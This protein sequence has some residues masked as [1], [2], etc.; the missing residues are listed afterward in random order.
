MTPQLI[1]AL[2]LVLAAG[3][4]NCAQGDEIECLSS[5]CP[6]YYYVNATCYLNSSASCTTTGFVYYNGVCVN[7]AGLASSN[8]SVV[9]PD[10]LYYSSGSSPAVCKSCQQLYGDYCIRCTSSSCLICAYSSNLALAADKSGCVN[11]NCAA[12]NCMI[13]YTD[14]SRCYKCKSGYIAVNFVCVPTS[15]SILNCITCVGTLCG[16]CFPGYYLSN[17]NTGCQPICTDTNC[18]DCIAP[19]ICGTCTTAYTPVNG[20]CT[21]NCALISVANCKSCQNYATCT[22]CVLGYSI[23]SGGNVCLPTCQV[24]KCNRCVSGDTTTCR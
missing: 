11:N 15:C 6:N 23:S 2:L 20:I 1:F 16:N 18:L 7:C 21:I 3:A 14:G 19:G 22:E 9:C 4:S 10:F 8:C 5:I 24:T 17:G 13:C 12:S